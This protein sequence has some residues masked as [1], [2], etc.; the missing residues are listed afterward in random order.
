[1]EKLVIGG[2]EISKEKLATTYAFILKTV[3]VLIYEKWGKDLDG[4]WESKCL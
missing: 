3:K 2:L 1:M 4:Q